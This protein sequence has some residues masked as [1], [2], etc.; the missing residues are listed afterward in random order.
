MTQYDPTVN[1]NPIS[2]L[3]KRPCTVDEEILLCL[4]NRSERITYK[5]MAEMFVDR[6]PSSLKMRYYSLTKA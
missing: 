3:T 2:Y 5:E 4:N 6:T 1:D